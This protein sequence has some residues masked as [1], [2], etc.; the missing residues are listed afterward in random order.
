MSNLE[1]TLRRLLEPLWRR[2][3]LASSRGVVT[4]VDNAPGTQEVQVALLKGEVRVLER[5]QPAGFSSVPEAGSEAFVVFLG[6]D[7]GHGIALGVEDRRYR[8]TSQTEG[9]VVIYQP[10]SG[11]GATVVLK[12]D[13]SIELTPAA[14]SPVTVVGDLE[15][16]GDVS[17]ADGTMDEMRTTYNG[18]THVENGGSGP[19]NPPLPPMT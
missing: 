14:G 19:T 3:R 8:P 2:I 18:H 13:G 1:T 5:P 7:R 15:V 4:R 11:G 16:S 10:R 17:D 6:G 12:S 9:E